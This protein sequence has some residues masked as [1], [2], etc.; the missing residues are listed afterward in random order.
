MKVFY[1]LTFVCLLVSFIK[2]RKK[3]KKALMIGFKKFRKILPS[4]GL[5]V[6]AVAI[7]LPLLPPEFIAKTLGQDNHWLG[8]LL[9]GSLGSISMMPGFIAFPLS[10]VL[11]DQGVPYM[12][13]AAFT[14]TLMM[15]GILSFPIEQ[16]YLGTRVA[17]VR[18]IAS[19][20]IALLVSVAVGFFFGEFALI[21]GSVL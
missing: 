20:L 19:L 21:G 13:I 3:T 9:G 2:D 11:I 10:G 6:V 4:F 16:K 12:V 8:M 15:V 18:N 17:V 1:I 5:M 7:V 14:T